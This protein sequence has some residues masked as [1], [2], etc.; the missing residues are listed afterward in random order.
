[1]E[2]LNLLGSIPDGLRASFEAHTLLFKQPSG[3][4][5]GILTEKKLWLL[6]IWSATD[7]SF[8]GTGECSV[9]PGLSP[10]FTTVENY[11]NELK[12][13]T[14]NPAHFLRNPQLLSNKPSLLFGLETAFID[15]KNGGSGDFFDTPFSLGEQS[16]PI[17]GLVWMGSEQFMHEQIEQKLEQGFSCIKMKV[18]AI[19]FETEIALLESIRKR[20]NSNQITLRVDAN[21]AF[22]LKEVGEKLQR[23]ADLEVHSIE[24]PIAVGQYA[25]LRDLC[26]RTPLP[27][28]LDEELIPVSESAKRTELLEFVKPQYII[29]KPSLHGGFSGCL[30]WIKLAEENNIP[31]WMTSALESSIGLNAIAQFA[32]AFDP[33]IPQGL[34]TGGLY[35]TNF[36][37]RLVIENGALFRR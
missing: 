9:I 25:A 11:E 12:T 19:D 21:G 37:T 3:T 35:E 24:Q 10:D 16:I 20:Y 6:R 31:W 8:I 14:E 33:V 18:G 36:E 26:E 22:S 28:A 23:L 15:W 2:N 29:L 5:R 34:G 13:I 32:A 4:S 30:E 17:N 27:I 7:K 1:M